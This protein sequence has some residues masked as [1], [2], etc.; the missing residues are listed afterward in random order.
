MK[1]SQIKRII[2]EAIQEMENNPFRS[3]GTIQEGPVGA[4][5][6]CGGCLDDGKCCHVSGTSGN[7]QVDCVPCA[8]EAPRIDMNKGMG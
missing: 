3:D 2:R 5:K 6:K 8:A 4:A 1:R 7:P